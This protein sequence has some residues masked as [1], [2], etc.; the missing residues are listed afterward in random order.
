MWAQR[1]CHL[2]QGCTAMRVESGLEPVLSGLT[3]L[4]SSKLMLP[5][6]ASPGCPW[7]QGPC[8]WLWQSVLSWPWMSPSKPLLA[9]LKPSLCGFLS[10]LLLPPQSFGD[11]T[12]GPGPCCPRGLHSQDLHKLHDVGKMKNNSSYIKVRNPYSVTKVKVARERRGWQIL[13]RSDRKL[14]I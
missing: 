10:Q 11:P 8:R 7:H 13:T 6:T 3:G 12:T 5:P 1:G 2:D 9:H 14:T 4:H